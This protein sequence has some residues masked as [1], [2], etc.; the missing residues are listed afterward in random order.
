MRSWKK[1]DLEKDFG[2]ETRSR[3]GGKIATQ[4]QGKQRM[5]IAAVNTTLRMIDFVS[6]ST[7]AL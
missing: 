5:S 7:R 1:T 6:A 4:G 3:R 2:A